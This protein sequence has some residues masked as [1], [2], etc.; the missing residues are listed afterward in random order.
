M[1][2]KLTRLNPDFTKPGF[3]NR[4]KNKISEELFLQNFPIFWIE[5]EDIKSVE[6]RA[7]EVH[8]AWA[9]SS[10][11][12][13]LGFPARLYD[14][15]PGADIDAIDYIFCKNPEYRAVSKEKFMQ[16]I[17]KG[18]LYSSITDAVNFQCRLC[19]SQT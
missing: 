9:L 13:N 5:E 12:I 4:N 10:V 11:P 17:N 3:L 18:D 7:K 16:K 15:K 2:Q 19:T 14:V 8:H 6:K 1:R